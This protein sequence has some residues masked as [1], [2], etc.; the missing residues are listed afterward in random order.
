MASP[1]SPKDK[2]LNNLSNGLKNTKISSMSP[3]KDVRFWILNENTI[4]IFI[5]ST[6]SKI[7]S[8]K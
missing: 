1:P 4:Y 6:S 2:I 7:I 8:A 5:Y 3:D